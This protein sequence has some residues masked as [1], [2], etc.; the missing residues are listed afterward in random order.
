MKGTRPD[1]VSLFSQA[2]FEACLQFFRCF[3]GKCDC[4]N[5]PGRYGIQ[6]CICGSCSVPGA[7]GLKSSFVSIFRNPIR[8][9]CGTEE[10]QVQNALNQ[11]GCLSASGTCQDQYRA[12]C[13][14]HSLSLH[15]I[16][17]RKIAV[18][19]LI[20]CLHIFSFKSLII[21]L[22]D[23]STVFFTLQELNLSAGIGFIYIPGNCIC[24]STALMLR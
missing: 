19:P 12:G 1:I 16:Q 8:V 11:N 20:P 5:L 2:D 15:G 21:H 6:N 13:C 14:H 4:Q 18:D 9:G 24:I 3:I 10:H 23:S 22:C 7:Q 17:I